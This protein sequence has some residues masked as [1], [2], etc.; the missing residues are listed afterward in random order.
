LLRRLDECH[1]KVAAT[2]DDYARAIIRISY[3]A[4]M[5]GAGFVL[6]LTTSGVLAGTSAFDFM[7]L[8][9]FVSVV[10]LPA[11]ACRTW[12][13]HFP[14]VVLL[15]FASLVPIWREV[16]FLWTIE[17]SWERVVEELSFQAL[18]SMPYFL[19]LIVLWWVGRKPGRGAEAVT[20]VE[21]TGGEQP[22]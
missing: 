17:A 3:A 13:Y 12:R 7:G 14:S 6:L 11:V 22:C 8:L 21:D 5:L 10:I 15:A 18:L 9:W 4:V 2:R 20:S 19:P 16:R 1:G